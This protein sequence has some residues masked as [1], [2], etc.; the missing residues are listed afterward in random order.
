[1]L[2]ISARAKAKMP[3]GT[4][5]KTSIVALFA[6]D[7]DRVEG[8]GAIAWTKWAKLSTTRERNARLTSH[9]GLQ[10]APER[11]ANA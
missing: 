5:D 1:M 10:T 11:T 6:R 2:E 8:L 7:I 3:F 4:G 9:K